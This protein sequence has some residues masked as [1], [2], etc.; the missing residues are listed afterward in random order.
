[1][2]SLAP[3]RCP[4]QWRVVHRCA[5]SRKSGHDEREGGPE[6][7]DPAVIP[8]DSNAPEE[9]FITVSPPGGACLDDG[10]AAT[11][12][13]GSRRRSISISISTER[14]LAPFAHARLRRQEHGS[15]PRASPTPSCEGPSRMPT[16]RTGPSTETSPMTPS[17]RPGGATSQPWSLELAAAFLDDLRRP[18][19]EALNLLAETVGPRRSEILGLRWSRV[20]CP[21]LWAGGP[22]G[23]Q[24]TPLG[25]AA[26]GYSFRLTYTPGCLGPGTQGLNRG[27]TG[28]PGITG[29]SPRTARRSRRVPAA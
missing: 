26:G 12:L 9:R 23:R 7:L 3:R 25:G 10:L 1:M 8:L 11:A 20:D 5:I 22:V 14:R 17:Q 13:S 19:D 28:W 27:V 18:G 24:R 21:C 29:G 16:A 6:R 2:F 4:R 15:A